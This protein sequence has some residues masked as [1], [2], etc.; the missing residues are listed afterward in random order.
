[1]KKPR[2]LLLLAVCL[3]LFGAEIGAA[4]TQGPTTRFLVPPYGVTTGLGGAVWGTQLRYLNLSDVTV[5]P[6]PQPCEVPV[7]CPGYSFAPKQE[8]VVPFLPQLHAVSPARLLYVP[9]AVAT[10]QF[11]NLRLYAPR[12]AIPGGGVP[13]ASGLEIPVVREDQCFRSTAYF[14]GVRLSI[15]HRLMLRVYDV[16]SLPVS[17]VEIRF[18]SVSG[19]IVATRVLSLAA[20]NASVA[21]LK[22]EP[23]YV[24][25]GDI[26]NA[27][28]ELGTLIRAT[29]EVVPLTSGLRFYALVSATDS[30]TND[31][32]IYTP[33]G[34]LPSP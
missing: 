11:M 27:V 24:Q 8:G 5:S 31:V 30:A 4:Q 26:Q 13:E 22:T 15:S 17:S 33:V 1:M 25:F 2:S 7:A 3:S 10:T 16:D 32:E 9:S 28:P 12:D 18:R 34:N 6:Q 20:S 23:G 14:V 21:G 29:I 19:E